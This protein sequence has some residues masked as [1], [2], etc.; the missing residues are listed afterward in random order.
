MVV[1]V[2]EIGLDFEHVGAPPNQLQIER[3][4]DLF[5]MAMNF[6]LPVSIHNRGASHEL[7]Q[8]I[9]RHKGIRGVMHYFALDWEWAQRLEVDY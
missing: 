2:G 3:L 9:S 6:D 4:D 7:L 8:T 1:V 5:G